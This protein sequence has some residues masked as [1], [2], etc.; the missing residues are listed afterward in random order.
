LD[1][2]LGKGDLKWNLG[3]FNT[4]NHDDIIFRRD[5]SS[6]IISQGY[7]S[8]VGKTRRHGIEAGTT[9]NYPQ[10]FSGIDDWHFSTNY[11]YLNARFIDGFDIPNPLDTAQAIRVASGS[12]IPGIPE[13]IFKAAITVDLWQRVSLGLD[14]S[15]SGNKYFRGDEANITAPLSG[16][17]VF[18]A[19]AEY[20]VTKNFAVFGRVDNIFDKNYNSFGVYG[21][22]NGILPGFNDGRFVSPGAPRAGW[23]GVR[24]SM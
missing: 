16:Y 21:Q 2:L 5:A 22:A 19:K 20:K 3:Y 15:Y 13:H 9:V 7:F 10:L 1:K 17:W 23:I 24:L 8:N 4:T 11:T 12:R 18:N 14:G 6:G